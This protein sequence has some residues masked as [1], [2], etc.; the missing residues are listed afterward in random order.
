MPPQP[1]TCIMDGTGAGNTFLDEASFLLR[2]SLVTLNLGNQAH[3]LTLVE[4]VSAPI[5]ELGW[6]AHHKCMV[7][8]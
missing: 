5:V 3:W 7:S 4:T 8:D 1:Q 2:M 6:H